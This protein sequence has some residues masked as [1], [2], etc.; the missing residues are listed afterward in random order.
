MTDLSGAS[1]G[2]QAARLV[3][4]LDFGIGVLD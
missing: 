1:G 3:S 4:G 2:Q